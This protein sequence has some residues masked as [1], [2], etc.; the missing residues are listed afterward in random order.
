MRT[1][2]SETAPLRA[3]LLKRPEEAFGSAERIGA[4]WREL[5][6]PA[7]PDFEGARR[8]HAEFAG[9]L[10]EMGANPT[11]LP[12]AEGT[13]L[14]SL[15]V[16]DASVLCG[17]GAILCRMGK[18]ARRGE[19]A[20]QGAAF[21]KMGLPVVG[22]IEE[23]GTLEGGDFLW[24]D[25]RTAAVGRGYRTNDDGIRQLRDLLGDDLDE[26]LVVPLPH[27][28]GA[29]DVF[30][31]MS[32]L[33]PVDRDLAV[34]Y[35]PL[36]PVP[37]RESLLSRGIGLV[38]V[39]D[40][41]FETLGCNVLA[42]APRRCVMAEGSPVTRRRLEAAGAEV[43]TFEGREICLKGQGGPTCLTRPVVRGRPA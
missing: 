5:G 17:H 2:Q 38:E 16:R 15:Y 35:S 18:A 36:L 22:R 33:S 28:R 41:E 12:E 39:P 32:I 19:P 6:Y 40:E 34:A 1:E 9:L 3:V 26:L 10:Q 11:Y 29:A 7:P 37:F 25:E 43:R 23:P 27:W 21:W 31:L 24:L 13:G 8:E 20:S 4:Q 42:V 14:D 30:H